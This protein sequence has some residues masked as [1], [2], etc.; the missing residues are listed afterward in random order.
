MMR[1]T[2]NARTICRRL[3]FA[4]LVAVLGGGCAAQRPL[5]QQTCYNPDA[6]LAAVL[7]PY[8]KLRA[9]GC[10]EGPGRRGASTCDRLRLELERLTLVCATHVPTLMA[11]AVIAHDEGQLVKSQQLLDQIFAQPRRAPDAAVLRAQIAI[12]EGNLALARRLLAEQILLAPDHAG[13]REAYGAAMYLGGQ[14]ADARRELD[15]AARLGAPAWRIAYHL[16]LVEEAAGD[17][18]AARRHYSEAVKGRPDWP[19][20]RARMTAIESG[21]AGGARR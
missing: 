2:Q 14:L 21:A 4:M 8:E 7:E 9:E 6:Q 15:I 18:E 1:R 5:I 13:L 12:E 10:A 20:P 19:L 17:L 11:N 3:T 16:G